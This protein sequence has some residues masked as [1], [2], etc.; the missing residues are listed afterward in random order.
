[1]LREILENKLNE[2]K[3]T[4]FFA[5]IKVKLNDRKLD[6]EAKKLYQK[7]EDE[8]L[9]A[10]DYDFADPARF[11]YEDNFVKYMAKA[12]EV[13]KKMTNKG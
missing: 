9:K 1:M 2:G 13:E 5:G 4:D 8:L 12:R 3:I 7:A 6:K 10:F 11:P